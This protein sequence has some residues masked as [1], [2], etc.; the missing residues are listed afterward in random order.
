MSLAQKFQQGGTTPI[1]YDFYGKQ[2]DY[3]DLAQAADQGL[4]EYLATLK[5]G[6]KDSND[7]RTA[8]AN[9]MAGIKD[10]TITFDNGQ[11]YDSKGRYTNSDK[12]NRDYYGLI[13]N[14]IYGKMGQSG[15]YKKPEEVP[16]DASTNVRKALMQELYNSDTPNL[17]DFLDLDAQKDGVRAITNR[18]VRLANVFQSLADNWDSRFSGY[19]DSDKTKYRQLLGE[20][21]TALRDGTIDPGDYLALSRAVGGVDFREMMATGTPVSTSTSTPDSVPVSASVTDGTT[22][23][24]IPSSNYKLKSASLNTENY[25]AQDISYMT[26]LMSKVKSTSG[27]INILRNSFYNKNYRFARD[28][29]VYAIFKD[30]KIS[31]KAGVTATLNALYAR[32]ALRPADPNNPNLMYIPGLRTKRGTAWVW[33]RATNQITELQSENIPYLKAKLSQITSH[34]QGGILYAN[35]GAKVPDWR[36]SLTSFDPSKYTYEWGDQAYGMDKEGNFLNTSFGTT[37][38]GYNQNRYT[39]D[40]NYRDFSQTGRDAALAIEN[41]DNYKAQTDKILSDYDSWNNAADKSTFNEKNNLFLRY[42]KWYDSQQANDANK[43]WNQ[44][45]LNAPWSS[46]GNNYYGSPTNPSND[47]KERIRNLRSDQMISIGHNNFK[48][49][50]KRYFYMDKNNNKQWV[51][52]EV[53]KNYKIKEGDPI[54][55]QD[56]FTTWSDYELIGPN[57]TP[58]NTTTTGNPESTKGSKINP[59]QQPQKQPSWWEQHKQEIMDNA[60]PLG[61]EATRLG[62][63]LR[64]NNK[65][66]D[67]QKKAISPVLKNTYELYSPVTGAFSE[68][69]LRNRQAADVRR[70]AAQPYTSDASLNTARS[71]EA[72]KQAT[73]LEYQGFIADDKEIQRTKQEALNR[74]ENNIAR[75]TTVAN[76]NRAAINQ[77]NKE[78]ADIEAQRLNANYQ[79]INNFIANNIVAPLKEKA[80]YNLGQRRTEEQNKK[81][82]QASFDM[83]PI[84][85]QQEYQKQQL[86]NYYTNEKRKIY[87]KYQNDFIRLQQEH[88]SD[89]NYNIQTSPEYQKYEDELTALEQQQY[90]DT[91]D[92]SNYFD[93]QTRAAYNHIYDNQRSGSHTSSP[94]TFTPN[95]TVQQQN[96]YKILNGVQANKKGG[97]LSLTTRYL[98][99]KVIK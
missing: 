33:D 22:T 73:D 80:T 13:A 64:T 1:L 32:G 69:Q 41:S 90:R 12:K 81:Y 30:S 70:Q 52:P 67:I 60:L 58:A 43:F 29:R 28:P 63:S 94:F 2:Y 61:A 98:L 9:I 4:N 6:E 99:N 76:E 87:R 92:M 82:Q 25:T 38:A 54:T 3:N 53:A 14:Y 71:L 84:T 31:S 45:K 18:S 7:F 89:E 68:M 26:N 21:A 77:A 44:D 55:T 16:W 72:N 47:V 66:A 57:D 24:H 48:A 59:I 88:A 20:A 34:R 97:K 40:P 46:K 78:K 75:R 19:S 17:Q 62:L 8:Y 5:R 93:T 39:T 35:S 49:T 91:F 36:D 23:T 37:G 56:G 86:T 79:G 83:A 42:S 96:W 85:R 15:L 95:S 11:F 74:Q 27:L 50:G 65:I 10:G 51:D